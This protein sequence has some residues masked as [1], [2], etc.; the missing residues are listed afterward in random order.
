[1]Y[2]PKAD[3]NQD[4]SKPFKE[5]LNVGVAFTQ[6]PRTLATSLH[7]QA[8]KHGYNTWCK[9]ITYSKR[10]TKGKLLCFPF[11]PDKIDDHIAV[12]HGS[13]DG[14]LVLTVPL[15]QAEHQ[16]G[17][18]EMMC[19]WGSTKA[20]SFTP[21]RGWSCVFGKDSLAAPG[22]CLCLMQSQTH[23]EEELPQVAHGPQVHQV[24]L[25]AAIGDDDLRA[26]ATWRDTKPPKFQTNTSL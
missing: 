8:V 26:N 25:I 19:K 11:L 4:W 23:H 14:I 13:S 3:H 7:T 15:L 12:L 22:V 2:F 21:F 18:H 20:S 9:P 6:R 24:V 1:M 17:K 16:W 10:K 5:I